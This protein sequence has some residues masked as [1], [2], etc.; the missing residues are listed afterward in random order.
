MN[1]FCDWLSETIV[2]SVYDSLFRNYISI[3]LLSFIVLAS[4]S[5]RLFIWVRDDP[6]LLFKLLLTFCG[7]FDS[8]SNIFFACWKFRADNPNKSL[9]CIRKKLKL[10][11]SGRASKQQP[12]EKSWKSTKWKGRFAEFRVSLHLSKSFRIRHELRCVFISD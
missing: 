10:L 4:Q 7:T 6:A 9:S 11:S 12:L 1:M 5:Q 3:V 8:P 2:I